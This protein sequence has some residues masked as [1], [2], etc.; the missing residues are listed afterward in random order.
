MVTEMLIN[1]KV[2][3]KFQVIMYENLQVDELL[4]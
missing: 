3:W 4:D 1:L 2:L